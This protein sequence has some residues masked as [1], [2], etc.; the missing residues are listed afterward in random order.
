MSLV[1]ANIGIFQLNRC[2]RGCDKM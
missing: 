1:A 2:Y